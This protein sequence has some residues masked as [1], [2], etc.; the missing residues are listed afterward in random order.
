MDDVRLLPLLKLRSASSVWQVGAHAG[1]TQNANRRRYGGRRGKRGGCT[2]ASV[3]CSTG[4]DGLVSVY[5]QLLEFPGVRRQVVVALVSRMTQPL[6]TLPLLVGV[7]QVYGDHALAALMVGLYTVSFAAMM[8]VTGRLVDRYGARKVLRV[9]LGLALAALSGTGSALSLRASVP[10]LAV[11]V[12][13][14]GACLPPVGAV[15]RAG[16]PILVPPAQLRAA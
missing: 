9:W 13:A 10:T 2:A 3:A 6:L 14:L 15:T 8:P 7:D 1:P 16:W 11:S 12:V 5:L 4:V